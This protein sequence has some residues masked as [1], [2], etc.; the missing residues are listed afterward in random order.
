MNAET[1][2]LLNNEQLEFVHCP[3]SI[4]FM[5]K[6]YL[7]R[8]GESAWN[9]LHLYTGQQDVPLSELGQRQ[10]ARV[11]DA[12]ADISFAEIYTSPLQRAYATAEPTARAHQQPVTFDA[13]LAE[14]HHGAWEGHPASAIRERYA[15]DYLLWQ[16]QPQQVQMPGG[17]SLN[18]VA[19]RVNLFLQDVL[20]K[21]ADGNVLIVTHD[22]VLRV[23]VLETLLMGLEYF[24]RWRFDNASVSVMERLTDGH[25]R[26]KSLNDCH[27]LEGAFTD[28][29]A[30]AL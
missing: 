18:D 21:H 11:A 29:A 1:L 30:Q 27:H 14:I 6:L 8:H 26:L 22:A 19:R 28:C 16:T 17:E 10:A 23:I 2:F 3:L 4:T 13:R 7:V 25:F 15:R 24:W 5:L 20:A 12:L 9:Q